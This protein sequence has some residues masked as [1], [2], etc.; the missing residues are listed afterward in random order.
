MP[1]R[2]RPEARDDAPLDLREPDR[3]ELVEVDRT[4]AAALVLG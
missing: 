3:A 2:P 1:N 4:H